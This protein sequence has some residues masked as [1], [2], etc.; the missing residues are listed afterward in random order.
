MRARIP[1]LEGHW[2]YGSLQERRTAPLELFR[3]IADLGPVSSFRVLWQMA[4]AVNHPDA[5]KHVLVDQAQRYW[6]GKQMQFLTPLLGQG[7]FTA[8]GE[9]WRR[10]RRLAQPAFH[11]ERLARLS[12]VMVDATAAM[13]DRWE[14]RPPGEPLDLMPEMMGLTMSVVAGALFSSDVSG[15][16]REVGEAL[17]HALEETNRRILA[18]NPLV[19]WLPSQRKRAFDQAVATLDRVIFRIIED[20]RT[21][22]TQANDLL[23]TL[24]EAKDAETGESMDDR[25][26][27][28][29]VMT[30]FLAG[31]ET[32]AV[33]LSWMFFLLTQHA[34]VERRVRAELDQVLGGRAPTAAELPRL[35]YT[36]RVFEETLRLYP[37]V[38]I[39]VRE[40]YR[41]D[42][43]M[44]FR[45]PKRAL[46]VISPYTLH[47]DP[48]LW[49]DPERFDPERFLPERS[50]GRPKLAYLP[51]GA[52]QRMCIGNH[53]ALMEA[54]VI[55]A[56]VLQRF[57]LEL[58]PDQ[59]VEPDA[60]VTLRPRNGVK[61]LLSA[62]GARPRAAALA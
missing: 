15:E 52:G 43:V 53:F 35:A 13:L 51:F 47:H 41:A 16:S 10:N 18:F 39:T 32:T 37:P 11:R 23:A 6:K 19:L 54:Q 59:R 25:Q 57:R 12:G 50:A 55:A 38:W 58:A 7:L 20:R 60:Q 31:H 30:L 3:R 24:M 26:L 2:F 49:P 1:H 9:V 14:R 27:R 34:E 36:Q 48:K 21:G 40:S 61:V 42:E 8:E 46:V 45:L 56:M 62:A 5:V 28:D 22:K 17:T 29:E 4:Y 33:A 44:G